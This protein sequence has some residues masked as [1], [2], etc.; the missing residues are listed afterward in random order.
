MGEGTGE[1]LPSSPCPGSVLLQGGQSSRP[2]SLAVVHLGLSP[3]VMAL[4]PDIS[5]QAQRVGVAAQENLRTPGTLLPSE[6]EVASPAFP[7]AHP[8]SNG[9]RRTPSRSRSCDVIPSHVPPDSGAPSDTEG[10][11]RNAEARCGH[12]PALAQRVQQR[13]RDRGWQPQ[14]RLSPRLR[15]LPLAKLLTDCAPARSYWPAPAAQTK[16]ATEAGGDWAGSERGPAQTAA[17][18]R[19]SDSGGG[20]LLSRRRGPHVGGARR[21]RRAAAAGRGNPAR[22]PAPPP[23]TP[24]APG[25]LPG[26]R[27]LPPPHLPRG[28][29]VGLR[30]LTVRNAGA[31]TQKA[32]PELGPAAGTAAPRLEAPLPSL[33]APSGHAGPRGSPYTDRGTRGGFPGAR[34]GCRAGHGW[35]DLWLPAFLESWLGG[36]ASPGREGQAMGRPAWRGVASGG[37]LTSGGPARPPSECL[38]PPESTGCHM[39]YQG[40]RAQTA[41]VCAPW[42]SSCTWCLPTEHRAQAT[43]R[44][45]WQGGSHT[46]CPFPSYTQTRGTARSNPRLPEQKEAHCRIQRGEASGESPAAHRRDWL[47]TSEQGP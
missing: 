31:R 45:P 38:Q 15:S 23:C 36:S 18:L 20:G 27:P 30:S 21:P 32:A 42:V 34:N 47:C 28:L 37:P 14:N 11:F 33:G 26:P 41:A 8:H 5:F 12:I 17:Q 25:L 9:R 16:G 39:G 2:R 44:M 6:A 1:A 10:V 3:W 19:R 22:A 43:S 24:P 4:I 13:S 35:P 40:P 46:L 29:R 7:F